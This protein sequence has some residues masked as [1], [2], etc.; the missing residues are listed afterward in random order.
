MRIHLGRNLGVQSLPIVQQPL[1]STN[2]KTSNW[3]GVINNP[4]NLLPSPSTP[5]PLSRDKMETLIVPTVFILS[6]LCVYRPRK[7]AREIRRVYLFFAMSQENK[8]PEN[9]SQEIESDQILEECAGADILKMHL[10][11]PALIRTGI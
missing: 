9:P 11:L 5:T 1:T 7:L 4:K 8:S 6:W 2:L 10:S 3:H